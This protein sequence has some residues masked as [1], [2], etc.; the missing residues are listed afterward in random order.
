[1]A[2]RGTYK[3]PHVF[4][5]RFV[6]D[7]ISMF[8]LNLFYI[9]PPTLEFLL[10]RVFKAISAPID[11]HVRL[12]RLE[13]VTPAFTEEEYEQSV[14]NHDKSLNKSL[15]LEVSNINHAGQINNSRL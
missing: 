2:R 1:M 8:G 9:E 11:G 10:R 7:L 6:Y 14:A 4:F 13:D 5:E 3:K 12:I 15:S